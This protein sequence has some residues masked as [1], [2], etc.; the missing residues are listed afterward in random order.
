MYHVCSCQRFQFP[1]L[2]VQ[3]KVLPFDMPNLFVFVIYCMCHPVRV[4]CIAL[5]TCPSHSRHV[6]LK[7][8][9]QSV[10][11]VWI[12][13]H[14]IDVATWACDAI[15]RMCLSPVCC[16][17]FFFLFCIHVFFFS[18]IFSRK[19]FRGWDCGTMYQNCVFLWTPLM[20]SPCGYMFGHANAKMLT[21]N[22]F[23]INILHTIFH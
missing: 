9:L 23:Y 8:E 12:T 16:C 7:F 2:S 11:L 20:V 13:S 1:A 15:F 4:S 5:S 17:F 21:P 6:T 22:D 3:F 14:W 10:F 18:A 19:V